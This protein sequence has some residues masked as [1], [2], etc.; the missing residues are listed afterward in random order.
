MEVTPK[1]AAKEDSFLNVMQVMDNTIKPLPVQRI[2]GEKVVGALVS[3]RVVL[4]A[5]DSKV[6]SDSFTFEIPKSAGKSV[7]VLLTDLQEGT[8]TVN[9][10][11]KVVVDH[12]DVKAES[13]TI[14]LKL[15]P[16]KYSLIR[17]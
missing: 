5:R 4:F 16:G 3:D 2:E 11:R 14:Y 7:K 8:W 13:G 1:A 12:V 9:S 10:G 6:L 15:G 17:R